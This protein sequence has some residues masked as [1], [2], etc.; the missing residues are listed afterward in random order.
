MKASIF[1]VFM[2]AIFFMAWWL[3]FV[4]LDGM[5]ADGLWILLEICMVFLIFKHRH[6][7]KVLAL[8]SCFFIVAIL[9][10]ILFDEGNT[11][12]VARNEINDF[13]KKHGDCLV[14]SELIAGGDWKDI[15]PSRN[16][17]MAHKYVYGVGSASKISLQSYE[18][19]SYRIQQS[20]G[21]Q[22]R[23]DCKMSKLNTHKSGS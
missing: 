14:F 20:I 12:D 11:D 18:D 23:T 15:S 21:M 4:T 5:S 13:V 17:K 9:I 3:P 7:N 1:L 10:F 22:I 6:P 8:T 16:W 2:A 19:G